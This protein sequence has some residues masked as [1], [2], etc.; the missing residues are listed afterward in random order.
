MDRYTNPMDYADV[1][2]SATAKI[3]YETAQTVEFFKFV[4]SQLLDMLAQ[5]QNQYASR[6]KFENETGMYEYKNPDDLPNFES[7]TAE[8][9]NQNYEAWETFID[10]VDIYNAD[11]EALTDIIHSLNRAIDAIGVI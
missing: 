5:V 10:S 2:Q 11:T 3:D 4:Q 6:D 1:L 9:A 7:T 8:V